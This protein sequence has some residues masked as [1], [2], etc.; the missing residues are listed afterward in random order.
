MSVPVTFLKGVK[1]ARAAQLHNLGVNTL[2]ELI[3]LYPV[4]YENRT[5]ICKISDMIQDKSCT[6]CAYIRKNTLKKINRTVSVSNLQI[7]D[8]TGQMNISVFGGKYGMHKFETGELYAF[9]GKVEKNQYGFHMVNPVFTKYEDKWDEKFFRIQPIYPLTNGL[10]QNIIRKIITEAMLVEPIDYETLPKSI[11][12][13]Y[14]LLNRGDAIRNVHFPQNIQMASRS[15][16]R[17]KFEELFTIQLM[18]FLVKEKNYN[19]RCGISF[20]NDNYDNDI[21]KF[22]KSLPFEL[23]NEQ[24]S[25]WQEIS[26]DMDNDKAMNRLVMGDV[27]SG[28]T[29]LAVMSLLKACLSGYQGVYMAPTEILAEQHFFNISNLL[30]ETGIKPVLL[31]GSLSQKEKKEV[32]SKIESGEAKCIIGTHALIQPSVKYHNLGIAITDE[33]HRF[34]VRQR[35]ALSNQK[36]MPDVL[37][38]T[39]TP[40]PR[41]LALILYG[42][43]DISTIKTTLPGRKEIKT[44][45]FD[46]SKYDKVCKRIREVAEE[47]RQVYMVYPLIEESETMQLRSAI[48]SYESMS[49]GVFSGISCGLLHGKMTALQKES[50]MRDFKDGKIQI[51]FS[52]TVVEVGVDVPNAVI[53]VIENA[54]RFGLSQLHQLRGRVGR[55]DIQSYC[56][57]FSEKV[58]ERMKIMEKSSDGFMLSEKDLEIRGPGDFFGVEQHGIP[59]LKI[60]DLYADVELLKLAGEAAK[61]VLK[62]KE[63]NQDFISYICKKYPDRIQL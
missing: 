32:L 18:L 27:G 15:R 8:E 30:L 41:T 62:N 19:D 58:T 23:T 54:Q 49:K 24:I 14:S 3:S 2:E 52:T 20:K 50:V 34:G 37:V 48:D 33:Q 44:Y 7:Y 16:K 6:V 36:T 4:K 53:M 25:V 42:D 5:N 13:K 1:E 10:T 28:K 12:E 46:Y 21:D 22:I 63:I 40:I 61:E 38:M 57:L 45:A 55:N 17:L 47:G 9:Y 51:L 35:A 29:I 39:A 56:I 59:N 31:T 43:M 60:A 26:K 11:I